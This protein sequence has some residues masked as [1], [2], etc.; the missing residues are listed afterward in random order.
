MRP[1]QRLVKKESRYYM[2]SQPVIC[3]KFI[4]VIHFFILWMITWSPDMSPYTDTLL[5][6]IL[7]LRCHTYCTSE[8]HHDNWGWPLLS[9][10]QVF[11]FSSGTAALCLLLKQKE[12]FPVLHKSVIFVTSRIGDGSVGHVPAMQAWIFKQTSQNWSKVPCEVMCSYNTCSEVQTRRSMALT[13]R[14]A[15]P[16]W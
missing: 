14:P 12:P 16:I 9:P 7:M 3:I 10:K 11:K 5:P 1:L 2:I 4:Q 8:F 15:Q 13:N 6:Q